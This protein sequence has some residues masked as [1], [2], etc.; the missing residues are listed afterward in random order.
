MTDNA[1]SQDIGVPLD[2]RL[3]TLDPKRYDAFVHALDNPRAPG[4][5]LKALLSRV[6]LWER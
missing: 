3:F 6:P 2:R 4:P 1:R 5:K